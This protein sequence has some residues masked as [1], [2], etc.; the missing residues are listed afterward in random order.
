MKGQV[1][2]IFGF[3]ILAI[4]I[5]AVII[6]VRVNLAG[7]VGKTFLSIAERQESEGTRAGISA[8][9]YTTEEKTGKSLLEL[10]GIA[11]Y[12]GKNKIDFGK[13]VGEID[14][15]KELQWR[16]D[17]IYGKGHWQINVPYPEIGKDIQMVFVIDTSASL[18]D[19]IRAL[20]NSLPDMIDKLRKTGRRVSATIY[21]LSGGA[22]CCDYAITCDKFPTRSYLHCTSMERAECKSLIARSVGSYQTE[23]DWG[24]GIACAAESGPK[25]GWQKFS[26]RVGIPI[27]DELTEGSE[28]GARNNQYCCPSSAIVE[29]RKSLEDGIKGAIDYDV[30]VFPIKANPC[31]NICGID[32]DTGRQFTDFT[33]LQCDCSSLVSEFMNEM[34]DKTGGKMYE[35]ADASDMPK[36][37]REIMV[38]AQETQGK[39]LTI[40]SPKPTLKNI[41]AVTLLVPLPLPGIY[42]KAY[43]YEW[44]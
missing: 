43:F 19:D 41:R 32:P 34:A 40:G 37:L 33:R 38:A 10:I 42:A 44:S 8:L 4:A 7:T 35:L 12:T 13:K 11:T 1:F 20:A 27:S 2:E 30:K 25:E 24:H 28:C 5:L 29:Q 39:T 26:V 23:E 15:E 3:L 22:S 6:L 14:I 9:M 17:A 16:F 18:C 21:L 31:G 36:A